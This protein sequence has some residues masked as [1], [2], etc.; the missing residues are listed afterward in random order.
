MNSSSHLNVF[1]VG[2]WRT[3][4]FLFTCEY[5]LITAAYLY[6]TATL[7]FLF[8]DVH[9]KQK[10]LKC[11]RQTFTFTET[12]G[13]TRGAAAPRPTVLGAHNWREWKSLCALHEWLVKC[14]MYR[15]RQWQQNR[16]LLK[17]KHKIKPK[18][19]DWKCGSGK[20]STYRSP[21]NWTSRMHISNV[22][23]TT[24]TETGVSAW[25]RSE[26]IAWCLHTNIATLA[27]GCCHHY[28]SAGKLIV[29]LPP[30]RGWKAESS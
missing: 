11:P 29:I 24:L 22:H 2:C 18:G 14:E 20:R 10:Q 26:F 19:G 4:V 30:H 27:E 16:N 12:K 3:C 25:H 7:H 5:T 13:V 17:R 1:C 8:G 21:T 28:Y 9:C 23:C 6:T 15:L